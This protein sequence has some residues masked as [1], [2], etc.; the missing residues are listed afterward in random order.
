MWRNW[1]NWLETTT[2]EEGREGGEEFFLPPPHFFPCF[3][4]THFLAALG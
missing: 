2:L 3:A 4:P 1:V